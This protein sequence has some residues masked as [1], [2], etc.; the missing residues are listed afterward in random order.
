MLTHHAPPEADIDSQRVWD[1]GYEL[2]ELSR[3]ESY[4]DVWTIRD[5]R[6]YEM[7]QWQQLRG[8]FATD[9]QA[10]HFLEN[11]AA[12]G[13]LVHS[14]Y[15]LK[16]VSRQ[17]DQTPAYVIW[18]GFESRSLE[19][20]MREYV[21]LPLASALWITRQC[22]EAL[23]ALL[24]ADLYHGD[25]HPAVVL[26]DPQTGLVKLTGLMHCRR[27]G[28]SLGGHGDRPRTESGPLGDYAAVTAPAHLRGTARDLF[29]LGIMLYRALA[30]RTPFVAETPAEMLRG[31]VFDVSLELTRARPEVTPP[32]ATLVSDLL[33]TKSPR[34]IEHPAQLVKQ[35]MELEVAALCKLAG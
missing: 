23:A 35:L 4:C 13:Q 31:R 12:V 17:L 1:L 7:F 14:P 24:Q 3:S 2:I 26:V 20:L 27:T 30:G 8:E 9:Q 32:L 18:E 28:H 16:L 33:A 34:Q 21:Q 29:A 25:L 19:A 15:F 22:A 5:R 11:E 10:R 6:T